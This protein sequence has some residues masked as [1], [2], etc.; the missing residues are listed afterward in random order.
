VSTLSADPPRPRGLRGFA[1]PS[2]AG[3]RTWLYRRLEPLV[4][5]GLPGGDRGDLLTRLI[6]DAED[7][8]DLVVRAAVPILA[9]PAAWAAATLTAAVLLPS[10]G[11]ALLAAGLLATAGLTV[12]VILA[13]HQVAA[14]PAARGAVGSWVLGALTAGEELA[15]LGAA[16]WTVAQLTERERVLGTRTR[17]VATATGLSRAAC[18]LAGGAGLAAVAWTGA[19]AQQAG[20]I[21]PV[22]LGVLVFLALGV[23]SLLQGPARRRRPPAGQPGLP[24]PPGRPRPAGVPRGRSGTPGSPEPQAASPPAPARH[25]RPARS[26]RDLSEPPR[27]ATRAPRPG[28]GARP[29]SAGRAGRAERLRQDAGR[30][31]PAALHRPECRAAAYRWRRR[32]DPAGRAGPGPA[33]LQPRAADA[34]PGPAPREPAP[35]CAAR[36]RRADHRPLA[37]LQLGPWLDRLES[38]LDTVLA[39]WGHPVSGG[40]LQRLSVARA[41]LADRPVLLLDEPA[42]HLDAASADAVLWAVL[43]RAADRSLLWITHQAAELAVFPEVCTLPADSS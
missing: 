12:A 19:A 13:S 1:S 15:A 33:G 43:A 36:D 22:E 8:Q 6:R 42:R 31:C 14:L 10:A 38:G 9:A 2:S 3:V 26:G 39:P 21:G 24:G 27:P 34:V 7:A 29:Q 35:R 5:G 18:V 41:L 4:P 32:A 37:E 30:P 28:P 16:E 25:R 20:R 11:R 17:A 40:E 23:A